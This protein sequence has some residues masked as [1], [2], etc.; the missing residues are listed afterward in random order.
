MNGLSSYLVSM[1]YLTMLN[2]LQIAAQLDLEI[3][4]FLCKISEKAET[5]IGSCAKFWT[6]ESWYYDGTSDY[7]ARTSSTIYV[8]IFSAIKKVVP[9]E[10]GRNA[11]LA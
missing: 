6:V 10:N 7:I 9:L 4:H 11:I 3:K 2:T 5:C 8:R 1:C